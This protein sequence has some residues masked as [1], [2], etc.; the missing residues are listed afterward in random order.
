[1]EVI[2]ELNHTPTGERLHI[3]FFGCRN[4]G[5]SSLV[6]EIT[7][8]DMSIVSNIKGTTTDPVTKS[9][10]LLPIGPVVIID[11]PGFDDEGS[12]GEQRI[13]Q[14]KRILR[15]CDIAILVT[16]ATTAL[17]Q[18]EKH[19]ISEFIKR[20]IPYIIAKNKIDL[21]KTDPVNDKNIIY[22]STIQK[23]GIDN[24]KN[25]ISNLVEDSSKK[26]RYIADFIKPKDIVILVTPIDS[27]APKG[28]MIMPQQLA[29][30]DIIDSH[31]IPVI[32]RES[33]LKDTLL[34]LK[35]NPSL[36]VTDSQVFELVNKVIPK[37]IPLTSFSI[38]MAR[39]KGFLETAINGVKAIK[40]LKNSSRILISEG[41]THHRQCEDIGTVKLPKLLK[42]FTGLDLQ[43]EWTNG[44]TFPNDLTRFDLII[45][46][47]ACMLNSN[48]MNFRMTSSVN[49]EIPFTNY[50]IAIAYMKGILDRSIKFLY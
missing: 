3:G 50:G 11:T 38:L 36:V 37:D 48:E 26:V 46:C 28:R 8:Q 15:S 29:I 18:V 30:R 35:K 13:N 21:L 47:G 6:N 39:Y 32:T 22:I 40:N 20:K 43:F 16:D 49:Q 23:K 2:M 4:V 24:L 42:N 33:E 9:M 1:M 41:C 44:L 19:L 14:A 7:N 27:S 10:E 34:S 31:A 25:A 45:H 17:N 5:K 12:L